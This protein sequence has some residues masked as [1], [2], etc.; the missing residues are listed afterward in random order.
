MLES[1]FE[2]DSFLD[3]NEITALRKFY[4]RLPKTLNSGDEKKAYTTG[5]PWDDLPIKSVRNKIENKFNEAK[6]TVAMF[7]EEYIP[8]GVHTD[9]F[10][11]DKV[12]Y[13]ALLFPLDFEEKDTHNIIFDQKATTKDWKVKLN[14][15]AGFEYT[16]KQKKLLDHI[17]E[18]LLEKLSIDKVCKWEKG[19]MIAWHRN[20]L[21]TS[22]NF[23]Q[24]G[25]KSKIALVLFM[26]QDD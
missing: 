20:L 2:I 21:H 10:K 8:W 3:G 11:D 1:S 17:D 6:V 4:Q 12:P 24:T 13:Y 15:H 7:L 9:Y 16:Q 18:A 14:E 26:N 5:F 19:K 23:K 25:M 22:D